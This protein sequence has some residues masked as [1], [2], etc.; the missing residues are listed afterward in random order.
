MIEIRDLTYHV[1]DR[2]II[3]DFEL[4]MDKG[5]FVSVIGANGAG[6]ST[7]LRLIAGE[8]RPSRGRIDIAGKAVSAYTMKELAG[9]RAY[10]HQSNFMEIPFR[11]EEV[12]SMGRYLKAGP[13]P[14]EERIIDECL[15][16]CSLTAIRNRSIR[17]LS[18]GEQQRV[19]LARVLAQLWDA[20]S[21]ILLLDEP[22]SS[23][24]I[25]YQH[26]TLAIA[27]AFSRVGFLVI[28]VLHDLNLA[29]QYS[30]QV[31][32]MKAGKK[33][34]FGRP[35]SVMTKPHIQSVFGIDSTV[36]TDPQRHTVQVQAAPLELAI[37][38]FNS[39]YTKDGDPGMH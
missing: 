38:D 23:M 18:G 28:A 9:F 37:S 5:Q 3:R 11:V 22:I 7:L 10:L 13:R 12:V 33:I 1:K 19:H 39:L 36:R 16:I 25:Q 6:K 8:L 24:D 14:D 17:Q 35:P 20:G 32:M 15:H 21:G 4:S 26:L 29:A 31:L 2:T 27:K 34:E 30:D